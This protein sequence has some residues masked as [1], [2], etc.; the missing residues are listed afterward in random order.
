MMWKRAPAVLD[1]ALGKVDYLI[2]DRFSATDIILSYP[3]NWGHEFRLSS[4][5]PNLL[6]YLN[7][8]FARKH[9]TLTRF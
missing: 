9:C 4:E 1:A 7:R 8:L 5:S 6:A 3:V 2:N